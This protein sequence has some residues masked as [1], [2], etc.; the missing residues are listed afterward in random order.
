MRRLPLLERK[1]RLGDVVHA[2]SRSLLFVQHLEACG[3]RLFG[4]VCEQDLEGVVGK[5]AQGRYM[6]D[7]Q[8]TSWVKI[9]NPTYSQAIDRHELFEG[10]GA[11][12]RPKSRRSVLA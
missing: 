9:K 2:W 4:K 8:R 5:W 3:A 7:G 10:R 6:C 12:V 11:K 1:H